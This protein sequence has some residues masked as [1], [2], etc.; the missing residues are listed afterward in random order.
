MARIE[1]PAAVSIPK[2]AKTEAPTSSREK[3][4]VPQTQK[5]TSKPAPTETKPLQFMV[6]AHMHQEFKLYAV[7]QNKSMTDLFL[8]MYKE[9]RAKHG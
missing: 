2:P 1:K 4:T 9:Y 6:S 7:E 3:K 5:A 8:A